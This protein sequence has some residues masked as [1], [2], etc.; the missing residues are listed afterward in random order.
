MPNADSPEPS[1]DPLGGAGP[2]QGRSDL[3]EGT[4]NYYDG[5]EPFF[6]FF[7]QAQVALSTLRLNYDGRN[8]VP[9]ADLSSQME[10]ARRSFQHS[11]SLTYAIQ[12]VNRIAAQFNK[13]VSIWEREC[14]TLGRNKRAL[15]GALIQRIKAEAA[16]IRGK[17]QVIERSLVKLEVT[18]NQ[19]AGEAEGQA[20]SKPDA[21][22]DSAIS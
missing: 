9:T 6:S 3:P 20:E 7:T 10:G 18:L 5:S 19:M 2:N 12:D 4:E 22:G 16:H 13:R 8:I 15:S 1:I 17:V 14:Q 21:P 11:G